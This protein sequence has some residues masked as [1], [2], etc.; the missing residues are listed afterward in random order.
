MKL[1]KSFLCCIFIL[2]SIISVK[3]QD[4]PLRIGFGVGF[5][6][7]LTSIYVYD[8][9]EDLSVITLPVEFA[10]LSITIR[11]KNFLF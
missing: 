3:A 6:R 11:S 5:G 1:I 9:F 4:D 2:L 10:D 7:D 8:G